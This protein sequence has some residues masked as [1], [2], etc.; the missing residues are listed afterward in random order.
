MPCITN[1]S[2][3]QNQSH[4]HHKKKSG[5]WRRLFDFTV[6][7]RSWQHD[8]YSRGRGSQITASG[9]P[10]KNDLFN[11]KLEVP[12]ARFCSYLCLFFKVALSYN[13][14]TIN[15]FKIKKKISPP[16][17]YLLPLEAHSSHLVSYPPSERVWNRSLF[18]FFTTGLHLLYPMKKTSLHQSSFISYL[19]VE[20]PTI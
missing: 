9:L 20:K 15:S 19:G 4:T 11:D 8:T 14:L 16:S 1:Y 12:I 13:E 10:W 3:F 7:C 6:C 5:R 17:F 18:I 2:P